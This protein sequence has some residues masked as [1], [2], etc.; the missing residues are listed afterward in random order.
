M[1]KSKLD[2]LPNYAKNYIQELESRLF[3][4]ER[5]LKEYIDNQTPSNI[6]VREIIDI[7]SAPKFVKRYIQS[8]KVGFIKDG[9]FLEVILRD[10]GKGI[11]L[12]YGPENGTTDEIAL[13]PEGYE[14]L[15]LSANLKKY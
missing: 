5:T 13:I 14:R 15:R 11:S 4:A 6:F 8:N 12:S 10:E 1:E 3:V 7:E 9:V 2:K